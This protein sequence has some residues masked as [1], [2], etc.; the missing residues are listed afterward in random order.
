MLAFVLQICTQDY[1]AFSYDGG[2]MQLLVHHT[3]C[4]TLFLS[5]VSCPVIMCLVLSCP[6]LPFA[7]L[8]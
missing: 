6:K 3:L 1:S 8:P 7:A 5:V 2:E 4:P